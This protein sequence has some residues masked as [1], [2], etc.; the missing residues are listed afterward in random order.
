MPHAAGLYWEEHG[1]AGAAPLILSAGLGGSATYWA[2]NLDS[3]ARDHR[4][5]LYDHRGTGRSER[6][7]PPNL[8]VDDMAD[9]VLALMDAL[10]VERG[11]L[12]G[13][14]AGGLIGLSL[15]LRFPHRLTKLVVINGWVRP[16]PHIARCF[17]VRLA[18]LHNSGVRAFLRAQP[19]FL[20]PPTWISEHSDS[21]DAELEVQLE[22]F[23]G[24]EAIEQRI[25]AL[26]AFDIGD[27]VRELAVPTFV[28]AAKDDVLV[29]YTCTESWSMEVAAVSDR[30][31]MGWGGHACNVTDPRSF[32]FEVGHF[33]A[34]ESLRGAA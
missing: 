32:N 17:E 28:I 2:P 13:H 9:D 10:G 27:K 11:S 12:V 23:Q 8:S 30:L 6:A 14:A 25:A 3:L 34:R 31:L 18:L 26:L 19:I 21:L 5:I 24:V 1:P 15:A 20:Y 33:L 29:P 7:L 4:V 16:D 22:Q